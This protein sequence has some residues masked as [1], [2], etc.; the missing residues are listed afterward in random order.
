MD[1][2]LKRSSRGRSCSVIGG[3]LASGCRA[4]C[5]HWAQR[6]K[7]QNQSKHLAGNSTQRPMAFKKKRQED[8]VVWTRTHSEHLTL[9]SV[10]L[11]LMQNISFYLKPYKWTF[12]PVCGPQ[13]K[14]ERVWSDCCQIK[15][16]SSM[17][18]PALR[19]CLT[20]ETVRDET[21]TGGHDRI[22]LS[23]DAS[24]NI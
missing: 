12:K 3:G 9:L 23:G 11:L 6:G 15:K 19:W 17:C 20:P 16:R 2:E 1:R 4:H 18:V 8:S 13:G 24:K 5:L 10:N 14:L 21:E 22:I 7:L